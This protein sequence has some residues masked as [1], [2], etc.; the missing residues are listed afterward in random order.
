MQLIQIL[1]LLILNIPLSIY[2]GRRETLKETKWYKIA[3]L[4]Q[5]QID[6]RILASVC[7]SLSFVDIV[8]IGLLHALNFYFPFCV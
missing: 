1:L 4:S 8:V 6:N 2:L 7:L 5:E 3:R